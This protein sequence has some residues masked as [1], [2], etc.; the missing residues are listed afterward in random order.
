MHCVLAGVGRYDG[1]VQRPPGPDGGPP[2]E[3]EL[4]AARRPVQPDVQEVD[5][6][7]FRFEGM[8]ADG[9]PRYKRDRE[10]TEQRGV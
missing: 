3:V 10:Y 1:M 4:V 5:V 2:P 7:I 8:N 6:I 9:L